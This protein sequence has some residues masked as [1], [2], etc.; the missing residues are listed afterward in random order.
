MALNKKKKQSNMTLEERKEAELLRA[1]RKKKRGRRVATAICSIILAISSLCGLMQIG[2]V[3]ANNHLGFWTP[4]Y[5]KVDIAPLLEKTVLTAEEYDLLYRQTGLAKAAIDDMRTTV[6]G[7]AKIEQIHE[8]FFREHEYYQDHYAPFTYMEYLVTDEYEDYATLADLQDGDI[9]ISSTMHFSN[10]RMGHSALV[11]DGE[12]GLIVEA[13]SPGTDSS[14]NHASS[15]SYRAN[16][17]ILRPKVDTE[18]KKEVVK[19]ARENLLGIPYWLFVGAY[20][21]KKYDGNPPKCSQCSHIV[22]TAY[23]K[24]GIDLD[25][26]GG[27]VVFPKDMLHSDKVEIVQVFGFDLDKL[28]K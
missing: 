17:I 26:N 24:F 4:T 22:W 21:T 19:Y 10:W 1:E 9:L 28:W 3:Y 7:R 5:E 15:F 8:F 20:P 6:R 12:S 13:V 11:V 27:I 23:R 18:T 14:Y 2:A 25:Y 16:F